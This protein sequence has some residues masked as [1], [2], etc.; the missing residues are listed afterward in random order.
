MSRERCDE[1]PWVDFAVADA[2]ALPYE[3]ESFDAAVSTQVYEYV[4]DV[5]AAIEELHRVL[6]PGG[7]ALVLDT[8]WASIVIHTENPERMTRVLSAWDEH[9][10]HPTLPR[11]LGPLLRSAGFALRAR[12]VAPLFNTE[13]ADDT[14]SKPTLAIIAGFVVGRQGVTEEEAAEWHAELAALGEQGDYFFTLNRY[15]FLVEKATRR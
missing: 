6:R 14:Y 1:Q 12:E 9:F 5:P 3:N 2:T 8:D 10:V 7:R 13:Y 4:A 11:T 15:L